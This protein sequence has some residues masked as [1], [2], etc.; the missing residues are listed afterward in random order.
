MAIT[1]YKSNGEIRTVISPSD[2]STHRRAIME[3]NVLNLSFTLFEYVGLEVN[4]Y[5]LFEEERFVL[6]TEYRPKKKSTV[7]YQYDVRFYGIESE[8]KKALVIFEEETSFSLD[9]TPAV[10]LQLIVDNI[11]RIKNSNAWTI[12][13]V[14]SSVRKTVVYDTVNCFDALKKLAETYE[15]EWWVEGTTLN[16][17]RCEHGALLE[18]GYRQG[19][20]S[21][22]KD[23][24]EHAFFFTRLY[25]LGSTRN[26]DRAAYGSKRLHL[27]DNARYVEQNTQLGIVEYSEEAAFKDIYPRRVGTVNRVRTEEVTGEDGNPFTIYYFSDPELTFNPNDYEIAGLVK[28]IVFESG[29]LNGRD[30]EVNW[31]ASKSE[32]EIIT[33]FPEAGMQLPGA[34]GVMIP[35]TGDKYVLYNLRMPDAYYALA[36][37]E[38][39]EAVTD[40]LQKYSMDTAVYKSASDYVY[41]LENNIRPVIGQRVKLISPEYFT[42]GSRE[43]RIVSV[44]RKLSNPPDA[45]IEFSNA[46]SSGRLTQL[47]NNVVDIQTA[48]KEQLDKTLFQI[49][50]SWDSADPTEYN[51]LSALRTIRLVGNS[52]LKLAQEINESF[53]H[54]NQEDTAKELINFLEGIDVEGEAA[55][56]RLFV[57]E[58]AY[59]KD[60]LSS[61]G[62]VS[63]FLSGKGWAMLWKEF[64]NAAGVKEKKATLELD[65]ITVRG[66]MRVYELIISQLLGENGTR[67]ITDMMRVSRIEPENKKIYLDTEK[68]VLYNPFRE[69]DVLMVQ[70]FSG[71]P[72]QGSEYSVVKQYELTV[73]GAGLGVGGEAREDWIVYSAFVGNISD[74]A[75]RDVLTR[76]DS[77][78]NPD[79]KGII[80]ETSVEPGSPYLDVLYG[81]K[82]D[83]DSLKLRL[84]KLSGIITYLWGQLQGYGLYA[85]NVYLTG[86]FRLAN[87]EDV[88]TR[89]EVLEGKLQS[90]MQSTYALMDED[91]FLTNSV[92]KNDMVG[93][94]RSN[95]IYLF[96]INDL[97]LDLISGFYSQKNTV[98]DV[99]SWDGRFMLRIKENSILQRN[100]FVKKPEPESVLYLSVK[101]HCEA[102]GQLTAGFVNT[103]LY[104]NTP[105]TASQG[106]HTVEVSAEWIGTGDFTLGFTGDIYIEQLALTNHPLEDYQKQ[107]STLFEQTD[108]YI[109]SVATEVN[110]IDKTIK[111]A[112]WIT[113]ATGNTLWATISTVNGLGDRVTTAESSLTVNANAISAV[114]TRVHTTESEIEVIQSTIESAGWITTA[115]GNTLWATISTVNGLGNRVTTAESNLTV[116][117]NAI[118][119][120]AMRVDTTENTIG[121]IQN[122]ISTA[123]WITTADGNTLWAKK[124]LENGS[125]IVSYINQDANTITIKA[126]KIDLEGGVVVKGTI[127]NP[128]VRNDE[129]ICIGGSGG[130]L[131]LKKYDNVVAIQEGSWNVPINLPW[132]IEQSGRRTCIVNY[133]WGST[134]SSGAMTISAPTGKYFYEDGISK[135]T[136][137]FSREVVELLGYGDN[138]TFYG[139][140]V[141]N[142]LDIMTNSKHGSNQK[143]L[144]QGTVTVIKSGSNTY[145]SVKYKTFDG[146]TLSVSRLGVGQYKVQH[147]LGSFNYTV[148][149][150]GFF[151]S[152]DGTEI[153]GTIYTIESNSFTVYTQDDTTQNEGSF[154]FQMISTADWTS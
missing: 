142:R 136:L 11:N 33:Q 78:T 147:N 139:W 34:G 93:W 98:A 15:T 68:G 54:K 18:L 148:M 74:V 38:L 49:L 120:V 96:T 154:N 117:A 113:T 89:F 48:F 143:Y 132:D 105:V 146:S 39:A 106:Y 84:G 43:S 87:G 82:T 60:T 138:S 8:L 137:S 112:G 19:L 40:F 41:F 144:A 90:A 71:A 130:V 152:I 5:T 129:T 123:G 86:S 107:V 99:A 57:R 21:L 70:H 25:P 88:R 145:T 29:E 35:K 65:E 97:P 76:V 67:I 124:S 135:N 75:A 92:F 149:L 51:V 26:I 133:K 66:A 20:K 85:E 52:I 32:F 9:D 131:N 42:A 69:G 27:P 94:E 73:S 30:F 115:T 128:F 116:N 24:N 125:E 3:E 121:G 4:D 2:N 79:R 127:R 56:D 44:S 110:N 150:T 126:S 95:D 47:E 83:P 13:Q 111:E 63:G 36:E 104:I 77:L 55:T 53:L 122:T 108:L 50:K 46:L 151:S 103:P 14:V 102:D 61:Q 22:L 101:Y 134:T 10:H 1:I 64:L 59:F 100:N 72:A 45:E 23:E 118:S 17:S 114:A 58:N 62:F 31:N 28:H 12:G 109:K 140:I 7:E 80:K 81:M 37:Q 91:N 16:L 141:V 153:W 6:L 119:A